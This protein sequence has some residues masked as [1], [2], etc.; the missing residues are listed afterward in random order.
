MA[1][2][3]DMEMRTAAMR[4]GL[5]GGP[6]DDTEDEP[7][8]AEQVFRAPAVPAGLNHINDAMPPHP[9]GRQPGS[10]RTVNN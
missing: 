1:Q 6:T 2:V 4:Q 9:P 8:R 10:N 3:L 7:S 5:P